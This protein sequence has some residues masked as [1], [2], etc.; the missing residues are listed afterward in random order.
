[1]EPVRNL[2]LM[3]VG[4][5]WRPIMRL[6]FIVTIAILFGDTSLPRAF[7]APYAVSELT[8]EITVALPS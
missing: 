2:V 6:A 8:A 5:V 1:M 3:T 7:W 4:E